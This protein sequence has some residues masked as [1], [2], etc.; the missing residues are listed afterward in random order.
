VHRG[1]GRKPVHF[2]FEILH[3]A[4]AGVLLARLATLR[5]FRIS[6]DVTTITDERLLYTIYMDHPDVLFLTSELNPKITFS[7]ELIVIDTRFNSEQKYDDIQ[8][9]CPTAP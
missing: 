7:P 5:A 3:E 8:C 6:S 4:H 1:Q 9:N 2:V